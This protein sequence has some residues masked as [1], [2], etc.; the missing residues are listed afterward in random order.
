MI[1]KLVLDIETAGISFT[2]LDEMSQHLLETRF[3]KRARN[4]EELEQA[5]ESLAF[6]PTTAQIVAVGMLNADT[7]Q[8]KAIYQAVKSEETKTDEGI[9]FQAVLSEKELLQKFWET[10]PAY[11]EFVTF[12]GRGFDIP[13]LMIR[14][15]IHNIR[16]SKNLMVN[17]Y[18]ESQ[19]FN[20]KHIDLADQLSFYGA[21]NDWMGLHFWAKAFGIESSKTDEM[22]G[23]KVTEFFKQGK[24][25]EIAEYCMKDVLVTLK[26]YQYWQKNLRFS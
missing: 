3:K 2:D 25:K 23:D 12:N 9:V 4:D 7:E 24:H 26:L 10:A 20:L 22:S 5:K 16:P 11:E 1:N 15:A 17:R 19:P 14:S 21:K 18:L 6:Y 13:F 8:G